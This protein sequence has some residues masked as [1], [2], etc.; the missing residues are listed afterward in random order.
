M[1]KESR[2]VSKNEEFKFSPFDDPIVN[3]C[4]SGV[5]TAGDAIRSFANSITSK[6]GIVIS[7]VIS[8][9]P[10]SYMKTPDERGT[11]VDVKSTTETNQD[12]LLEVN[13]YP[14]STVHQRNL[15][16][17]SQL[18]T[19]SSVANTTH[20][21]MVERMPY[22]IAINILDYPL[23]NDND[24]W[25]QPAKFVYE[26]PPHTIALS[27]LVIYDIELPKFKNATPDWNDTLYCWMYALIKAH[28]EKKTMRE[29]IEMAPELQPFV[30]ENVGFQQF[31]E[32]YAF[33]ASSE[34]VRNEYIKWQNELM[35]QEGIYKGFKEEGLKEGLKK[36]LKKG[37][38]E[39]LKTGRKEQSFEIAL[40]MLKA[41]KPI[42]EIIEFTGLTREEVEKLR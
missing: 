10:Q 12:I 22:V 42:D 2:I 18:I 31:C 19:S 34:D 25:L 3:A 11:R 8:V 14:D 28:E 17:A 40:K 24:D 5:D 39:G 9:T 35:R 33:V 23:R 41:K 21:Q 1:A 6:D 15:L 37:R 36:G 27:Q 29:V 4:F 26:K 13:M 16:A 32:R 7:K 20:K 30:N 38:E